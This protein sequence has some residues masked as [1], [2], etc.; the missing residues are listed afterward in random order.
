M[1]VKLTKQQ[2]FELA[3]Q[4]GSLADIAPT[5]ELLLEI[6]CRLPPQLDE[7]RSFVVEKLNAR[8]YDIREIEVKLVLGELTYTLEEAEEFIRARL[9]VLDELG[10]DYISEVITSR[11]DG[12]K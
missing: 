12:G 7:A 1:H 6:E 10:R 4:Y 9:D 5:F 11:Q 8:L 3:L 2:R